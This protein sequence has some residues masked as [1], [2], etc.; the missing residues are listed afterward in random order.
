MK[1]TELRLGNLIEYKIEDKLDERKEWWETNI[2]D[3]YDLQHMVEFPK[4][5]VFRPILLTEKWLKD[6]GFEFTEDE[7]GYFFQWKLKHKKEHIEFGLYVPGEEDEW[8][9][10]FY[11][12]GWNGPLNYV[13]QLQNIYFALTGEELTQVSEWKN[14]NFV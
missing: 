3:I 9:Y 13:H 5:E 12:G 1:A 10:K 14:K 7:L 8:R 4:S 6:L 11:C 2:V